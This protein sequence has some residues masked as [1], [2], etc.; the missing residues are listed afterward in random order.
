MYNLIKIFHILNIVYE[1]NMSKKDK[2]F[3]KLGT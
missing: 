2:V 3:S 1:L